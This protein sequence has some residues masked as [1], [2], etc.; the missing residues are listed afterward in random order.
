MNPETKP[1][2]NKK[3]TTQNVDDRPKQKLNEHGDQ[4]EDGDLAAVAGDNE[5]TVA[6]AKS[7]V[8]PSIAAEARIAELEAQIA[9]FRDKYIRAV[10]END[11][12]RKRAERE[13]SDI[14]KYAVTKFASDMLAIADNLRRAIAAAAAAPEPEE[15]SGSLKALL[16]GV[17]LTDQELQKSLEK[18]GIRLIAA[19][20][21]M[22]DPHKHQAVMEQ[23]DASVP[24]GTIL[25]VFQ[26]GYQIED[27][28]LRPSMVVVAKGGAKISKPG[29]TQDNASGTVAEQDVSQA[30]DA[31][32]EPQ[33]DADMEEK[34]TADNP[35]DKSGGPSGTL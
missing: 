16:E 28:I 31:Q 27:R 12:L 10:A 34:T 6:G 1:E 25:Q 21:A 20:G 11:N 35:E 26:D 4:N 13:K 2:G 8:D 30:S 19:S 24:A 5:S 33:Y 15:Q 29:E 7:Y 9:E 14:G 17:E 22:F 32:P 18:N 23:D 3:E